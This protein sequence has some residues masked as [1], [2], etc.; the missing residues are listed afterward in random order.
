MNDL[1]VSRKLML[2]AS[3]LFGIAAFLPWLS[4]S[5]PLIGTVSRSGMSEA[6]SDGWL[7]VAAAGLLAYT[8]VRLPAFHIVISSVLAF[9][10]ALFEYSLVSDRI[11]TVASNQFVLAQVG[12]G[13]WLLL[14][15]S[16]ALVVVSFRHAVY[17]L[18]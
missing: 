1:T 3:I 8:A 14:A 11:A 5:A 7:V 12:N 17:D 6:F 13:I 9:L 16:L 4:V 15:S 10:L 18:K 2:A